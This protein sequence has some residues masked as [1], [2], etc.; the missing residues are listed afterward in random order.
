MDDRSN[1]FGTIY[2]LFGAQFAPEL[3]RE[4]N[5]TVLTSKEF[6]SR[7]ARKDTFLES[8]W[9]NKRVSLIGPNEEAKAARG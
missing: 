3:G 4:I 6:R 7:R 5:Y 2:E 8:V 9:H 1:L